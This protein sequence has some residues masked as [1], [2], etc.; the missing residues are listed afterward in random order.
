MNSVDAAVRADLTRGTLSSSSAAALRAAQVPLAGLN[1]AIQQA[2]RAGRWSLG[3][4]GSTGARPPEIDHACSET[5]AAWGRALAAANSSFEESVRQSQTALDGYEPYADRMQPGEDSYLASF[6]FPQDTYIG[7][8]LAADPAHSYKERAF[9]R[10]LMRRKVLPHRPWASLPWIDLCNTNLVFVPDGP[11]LSYAEAMA[12]AQ[13]IVADQMSKAAPNRLKIT[14]IDALHSGRSA[15]AFLHLAESNSLIIDGQVWTDP[16]G[17]ES[18]LLRV[19]DRMAVLERTC[20]KNE[21]DNLD[22]YNAQPGVSPEAHQ[23]VVVAGYPAGFQESSARLLRQISDNST[24]AGIC[25]IVVMNTS[26]APIIGTTDEIA[27]SYAQLTDGPG[28]VNGPHWWSPAVLPLGEFVLGHSG[29]PYARVITFPQGESVWVPCELRST[30]TTVQT[31]I[32]GGYAQA[33]RQLAESGLSPRELDIKRIDPAARTVSLRSAM[34]GWLHEQEVVNQFPPGWDDFLRSDALQRTGMTYTFAELAKQAAYLC[35]QGYI[36]AGSD[37]PDTTGLSF[38]RLTSKG[39]DMAM[40]GSASAD[41]FAANSGRSSAG[42]TNHYTGPVFHGDVNGAQIAWN[43][44]NVTQTQN[45]MEQVTPGFEKLAEAVTQTLAQL[46]QFGLP[47]E[48]AEDASAS[49]NEILVEVVSPSP[50]RGR[51]RRSLATLRGFLQ[52]VATQAALGTGE[53][54]HDLA[55]AALDHLQ[56]VIF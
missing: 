11:S 36:A 48:D 53:G 16:G 43:N 44:Q 24:R 7:D 32:I 29:Q 1:S 25:V 52:P 38:P 50:D 9:P 42:T 30:K 35:E 8:R 21:F 6:A 4:S 33:S 19:V 46:S 23:V 41:D 39:G 26:M 15:G 31:S 40:S 56:S 10:W 18:A 51:I 37:S 27:P 45:T 49:A 34:I 20:L 5:V 22:A 28:P 47:P 13:G 12:A 3:G 55:K 14:W 2:I 17:I 54:S